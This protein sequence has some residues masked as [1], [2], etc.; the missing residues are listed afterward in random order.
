MLDIIKGE[1]TLKDLGR[2][3]NENAMGAGDRLSVRSK[4]TLY[5]GNTQNQTQSQIMNQT[6][7]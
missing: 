7:N 5:F 6:Q 4:L 1:S 3:I 2:K